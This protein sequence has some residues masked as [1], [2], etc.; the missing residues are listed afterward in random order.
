LIIQYFSAAR[1]GV[2]TAFGRFEYGYV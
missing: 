2:A 1:K